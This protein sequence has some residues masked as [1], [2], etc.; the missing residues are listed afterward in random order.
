MRQVLAVALLVMTCGGIVLAQA[1]APEQ[2]S[3]QKEAAVE[4]K[5]S[6]YYRLDFNIREMQ[7]NKV[8]NTRA[9]SM[10]LEDGSR[11]DLKSGARVPVPVATGP[12]KEASSFQYMDIGMNVNCRVRSRVDYVALDTTVVIETL[13]G[14][15][16]LTAT[17]TSAPV[18]HNSRT[19]VLAGVI[20][21]RPTIIASLDDPLGNRRF[22]IEVTATKLK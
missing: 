9:Y 16:P 18:V 5:P 17:P 10:N 7:D 3:A 11:G 14:N 21:G 20:P 6:G 8:I 19:V 13:A 1:A 22:Q 4:Q 2:G 15:E 12:G